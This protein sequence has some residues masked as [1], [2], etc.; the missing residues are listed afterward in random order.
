MKRL[1]AIAILLL[2]GCSMLATYDV[3]EYSILN[4]IVTISQL[5]K[6]CDPEPIMLL[7]Y[8]VAELNNY[9]SN[10]PNNVEITKMA[11]QLAGIVNEFADRVQTKKNMS[12]TY[13]K[14]KMDIIHDTALAIQKA[15]GSKWR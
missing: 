1:L 5:S 15:S 13:C 14:A 12:P 11:T 3:G 4:S 8:K 7:H 2:S 10:R 6:G 9:S